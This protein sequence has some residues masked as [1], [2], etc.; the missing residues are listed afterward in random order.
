MELVKVVS[1][2]GGEH[3][4]NGAF[5]LLLTTMQFPAASAGA[6]FFAKKING[7]FQGMMIATTPN[8]C[9]RLMFKKPGVFKL[10][11]PCGYAASAK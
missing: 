9:R 4:V 7:A 6:A 11:W 3:T 2:S 8:G 10:V 1:V 5:S